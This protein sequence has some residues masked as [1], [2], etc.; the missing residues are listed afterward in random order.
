MANNVRGFEFSK[1]SVITVVFPNLTISHT[2][3][4][5]SSSLIKKSSAKKMDLN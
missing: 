2:K 4:A 3:K 5:I 1:I